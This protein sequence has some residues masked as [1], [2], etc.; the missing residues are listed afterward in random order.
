[1]RNGFVAQRLRLI[2]IV[3]CALGFAIGTAVT[4]SAQDVQ[5]I[6]SKAQ[7]R[8]NQ[9]ALFNEMR[10][11]PQNLDAMFA[12]AAVSSRLEDYE[13][14]ISTLERMLIFNAD[15]PRVRLELGSLYFR[16]GAYSVAERY[17][18]SVRVLSDLPDE[19]SVRVDSYLT[20]IEKRQR[21]HRF[22][23][24]A[25]IAFIADTNANLGPTD[26]GVLL[27]STPAELDSSSVENDDIGGRI[28]LEA[29]HIY[30]LQ[31]TNTDTW[32]TDVS[33]LG[34]RYQDEDQGDLDA[35]YLRSG[36]ELSLDSLTF[37]P[38]IRPFVDA[39]YVRA[40]DSSLYRGAGGGL[41][42][43]Q[44]PTDELSIFGEL[45]GGYRDY[46]TRDDEDGVVGLARLGVGWLPGRDTIITATLTGRRD[47]ADEDY[48]SNSEGV[49]RVSASFAYDPGYS[50]AEEKWVLSAY[51]SAG[52]RQ[53]DDPDPVISRDTSRRDTEYRLGANHVYNFKRGFYGSI[54]VTA[55]WRDS[56][57]PNFDL[58]NFGV[59]AAV[60]YKF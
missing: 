45:R 27:F 33:Y 19:V 60:G 13:A 37:G 44:T 54:G 12:Y 52:L 24:R 28:R 36:P 1:M 9:T 55:L 3:L 14:A 51:A 58:E 21:V 25:E 2:G 40:D 32:R 16:I 10:G 29:S 50:F 35:F 18:R 22:T 48:N 41:Q 56:N 39:E 34:R 43:R 20:E 53:F 6:A 38:K 15:L 8:A 46:N 31:R 49:A 26:R 11:D 42:Y 5:A 57:L 17:F 30:D 59:S 47:Q 7:L 4:A 23:G